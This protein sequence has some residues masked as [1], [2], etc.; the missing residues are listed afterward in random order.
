[1]LLAVFAFALGIKSSDKDWEVAALGVLSK[2][3]PVTWAVI[4]WWQGRRLRAL[5]LAGLGVAMLGLLRT[6]AVT[7]IQ[8]PIGIHTETLG[9]S[10]LAVV[11][12]LQGRPLGLHQ[13]SAL[14]IEA[15]PWITM[16]NAVPGLLIAALVL[17]GLRRPFSWPL[18]WTT[19]GLLVGAIIL[20]SPLFSTQYLAWL[21]PF[22]AG[23]GTR[24]RWA[25]VI[26]A[27]SL[28]IILAFQAALEGEMWWFV[29]VV[30]RNLALLAL[31]S[32]IAL[33]ERGAVLPLG[34]QDLT[35]ST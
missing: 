31:L 28:G 10:I 22:V 14:Y 7:R 16:A 26:N 33:R 18:A 32:Y 5:L 19:F 35:R 23:R 11:R 25:F 17:T 4:D 9:G 21:A 3:W 6:E 29:G 8:R 12:S 34:S 13:T 15:A 24:L 30:M 20:A 1:V 27:A 2:F